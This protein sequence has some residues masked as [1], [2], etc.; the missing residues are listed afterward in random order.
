VWKCGATP[1]PVSSRL[2]RPEREAIIALAEP[3]LVV[4]VDPSEVTG[5]A[6]I[7]A[8]YTPSSE[9]DDSPLS[10]V[11]ASCWKAPTSGGSTGRPK[12]IVSTQPATVDSVEPFGR[13]LGMV[14]NGTSLITGPLYHNAPFLLSTCTLVL[15]GHVVLMPRFDALAAV[16]LAVQHDTDWVYLVPTMMGRISRLTPEQRAIFPPPSLRVVMHM[17]APCPSWLKQEWIDWLGPSRVWELFGATEVQSV[18]V[19]TGEEWLARPGTVGKPVVG[20]MRILDADGN[21]VPPST[22]GEVWMRRGEGLETPYRYIG[23]EARRNAEGWESVGDMGSLDADGY[24]YLA[25]RKSDMLLVGGAN[26]YPA[27]IENA[28]TEHPAVLS[29]IVIGLPHDD[30][31]QVPHALVELERPASDEELRLHLADRL[32]TYKIPRTFER[33]AEPLRD[34]AGK[35]RRSALLADRLGA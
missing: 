17:A 2:P 28:L 32:V 34:D 26:V 21:E 6:V 3:T 27:E 11:A 4:G 18:T 10:S 7:P 29:A 24:L 13:L 16:E 22:V 14:D 1:Q 19:M 25:D 30:L 31:G 20:E 35:A 23:A 5:P 9:L 33:V 8:G 12:L 15:G